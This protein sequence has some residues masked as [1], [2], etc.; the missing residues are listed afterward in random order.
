[1]E[2]G[3]CECGCGEKTT[4]YKYESK[5]Q[6]IPKGGYARFVRG[7]HTFVNLLDERFGKLVAKER[8]H[9]NKFHRTVWRCE[10][11]CGSIKEISSI[12]LINGD[13]QSCGCHQKNT[14]TTHGMTGSKEFEIFHGSKNRAKVKGLDFNIELSDIVI[15]DTCPYLGIPIFPHE[16]G[17]S[18]YNSP[19][20]DRIDSSMGYVKGNVEVISYRANVIKNCGTIEEHL[21]IAERMLLLT[22]LIRKDTIQI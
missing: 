3:Y 16:G 2:I 18:A 22:N 8:L 21:L 14:V 10:C 5:R 9:V 15:P 6:E 17:S 19:T 7:H 4:L 13:S 20:L 11:D 1:M 12:S